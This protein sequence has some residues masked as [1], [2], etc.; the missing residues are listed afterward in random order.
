[1]WRM[2]IA[3]LFIL[4]AIRLFCGS[5][6]FWWLWA[7]IVRVSWRSNLTPLYPSRIRSE[8]NDFSC[9]NNLPA[10]FYVFRSRLCLGG[11]AFRGTCGR[12]PFG[13]ATTA[14]IPLAR[15]ERLHAF[16]LYQSDLLAW[17]F[18]IDR[19]FYFAS[20]LRAFVLN[21]FH[22]IKALNPTF[23]FLVRESQGYEPCF[24]VSCAQT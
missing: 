13:A 1:M 14:R 17:R 11:P 2:K 3:L 4:D 15:G 16:E 6:S 24:D 10:S 18:I 12:S 5:K 20:P 22:E 19:V 7:Q 9:W 8:F 23:P 21:N